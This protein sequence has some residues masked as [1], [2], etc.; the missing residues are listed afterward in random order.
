MRT[1]LLATVA[2]LAACNE[3]TKID[4]ASTL[5]K[6][7]IM[8]LEAGSLENY[9]RY[10]TK[11]RNGWRGLL[12]ETAE[13]QGKAEL[14]DNPPI[15]VMDGGCGVVRA[16]FDNEMKFLGASCNGEG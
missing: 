13:G 11:T 2:M 10:Y 14:T 3:T 12:F 6:N 4:V 16:R 1:F 7:V 8:P 15:P 5:D 9:S